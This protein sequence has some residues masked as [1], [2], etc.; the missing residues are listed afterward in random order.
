MIE[1]SSP[2][3]NLYLKVMARLTAM[4][5][6]LRYIDQDLGQLEHY[7][8]RPAVSFPCV[9][10]DVDAFD[11]SDTSSNSQV[12]EGML[13]IRLGVQA[14]SAA[15]N[16]APAS[17]QLKAL[18]YYELEQKI[19]EALHGWR[20]EGFSKL[21]RRKSVLED[22][23]DPIRVRVIPYAVTFDDST[24]ATKYTTV[25]RPEATIRTAEI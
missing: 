21:L 12:G 22:R 9:L 4:V 10:I 7:E 1:T 20:D 18:E 13:K 6:E 15:N 5:P 25:A 11:F 14:Y 2:F 24:T 16:L 19:H 17:V 23:N 8:I 3:A